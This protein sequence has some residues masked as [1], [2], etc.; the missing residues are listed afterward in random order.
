[1]TPESP[2]GLRLVQITTDPRFNNSHIYME[3][4]VFTPD[5][6]RFVYQRFRKFD[7]DDHNKTAHD[8]ILYLCD[9]EDGFSLRQLTDEKGAKAPSVSPDGKYVYYIVDQTVPGGGKAMLKRVSLD[10]FKR[11][12]LLVIDSPIPG[13]NYRPSRYYILSTISSDGKRLAISAFLGDGQTEGSPYGLLIFDL[14]DCSVRLVY[15]HPEFCNMHP[16]YCQSKDAQA[17]HDIMI[18]HNHGSRS[19]LQG[20]NMKLVSDDIGGD[21]H[22]I[23]DD[24]ANWRDVPW[25]RDIDEHVHG[26]ECW[27][28]EG[29]SVIGG[30][31]LGPMDPVQRPIVEAWPVPTDES[32]SHL[33]KN[34]P[35]AHRNLI[36]REI[37]NPRFN[38]FA[39][40]PSGTKMVSDYIGYAAAGRR[41]EDCRLYIGTLPQ[42]E[43]SCLKVR[44]L[45]RPGCSWSGH[46]AHPH[47]FLSPDGQK[48]FFNSDIDGT[49]QIWMVDGYEYP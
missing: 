8:T 41:H 19:D 10:S 44:Y 48:A 2:E 23:R 39:F 6:R 33:G 5:S 15:E 21:I 49:L 24:G 45:L 17:S 16:Q 3:S 37:D 38:H 42:G 18:Q 14:V 30:V 20:K 28:G 12:T 13:T 46:L 9:I 22:V 34:L 40:D 7:P 26:H 32:T 31:W 43:D 47:P 35:G 1:L 29:L 4:H 36:T 25:G 27:R 11:E